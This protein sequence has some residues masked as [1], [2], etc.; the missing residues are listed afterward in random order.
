V[1]NLALTLNSEV[2]GRGHPDG[3]G[4]PLPAIPLVEP[5]A[6][7]ERIARRRVRRPRALGA[8][9]GP[10]TTI[11]GPLCVRKLAIRLRQGSDRDAKRC[12]HA[13]LAWDGFQHPS[14]EVGGTDV[15][16]AQ[17]RGDAPAGE[18]ARLLADGGDA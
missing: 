2:V 6:L 7:R 1:S 3:K 14:G 8:A 12:A 4:Q 16:S 5:G 15:A 13:A 10:R 9:R 11:N 17:D 18:P